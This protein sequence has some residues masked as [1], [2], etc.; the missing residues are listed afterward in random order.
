MTTQNEAVIEAGISQE[1]KSSPGDDELLSAIWDD[2]PEDEQAMTDSEEQVAEEKPA[3]EK[4][5]ED[6][7]PPPAAA[8]D[9][10]DTIIKDGLESLDIPEEFFA[11]GEAEPVEEAKVP[12]YDE[13]NDIAPKAVSDDEK[14]NKAWEKNR[15]ETRQLRKD[16]AEQAEQ[17]RL[18]AEKAN[19]GEAETSTNLQK[20]IEELEGTLT[21][22]ESEIGKYSLA[23]TQ[24]FKKKYDSPIEIGMNRASSMLIKDGV[25]PKKAKALTRALIPMN[26]QKRARILI[27]EAPML[28]AALVNMFEE[29]EFNVSRRVGA[30]KSWKAEQALE[31]DAEKRYE[32]TQ[33]TH[34]IEESLNK[35]VSELAQEGNIFYRKA[36][37]TSPRANVWNTGVETRAAAVRKVI[38]DAN[39]AQIA[40]YVADGMTGQNMR[41]ENKRLIVE[42]K[43]LRAANAKFSQEDKRVLAASQALGGSGTGGQAKAKVEP[44]KR[45]NSEILDSIWGKEN[46][47]MV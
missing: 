5:A 11:D 32:A 37:S 15:A 30:L 3:E 23:A 16:N 46:K 40:K 27:E 2:K 8:T 31:K 10:I 24:S 9:D 4:P 12:E 42:I 20:R 18:L 17:L 44:E 35:A 38:A 22:K 7:A 33:E 41:T 6:E 1:V 36:K 13:D 26:T 25:D 21:K 39:M 47:L 34:S 14:A 43:S 29:I 19:T 28:H 45:T